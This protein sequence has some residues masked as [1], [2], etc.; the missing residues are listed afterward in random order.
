MLGLRANTNYS[1]VI[2]GNRMLQM[3]NFNRDEAG[4]VFRRLLKELGVLESTGLPKYFLC[5]VWARSWWYR[6]P[7]QDFFWVL[8]CHTWL[9]PLST[10]FACGFMNNTHT[11]GFGRRDEVESPAKTLLV[12]I[13]C[14]AIAYNHGVDYNKW[15]LPAHDE[16]EQAKWATCALRTVSSMHN[17]VQ[18]SKS[19]HWPSIYL[20]SFSISY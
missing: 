9:V 8:P 2:D 20:I 7:K 13:T 4:L 6:E 16:E 5:N 12:G 18:G 15:T 1:D 17:I 19:F 11:I 10:R 14:W 3:F